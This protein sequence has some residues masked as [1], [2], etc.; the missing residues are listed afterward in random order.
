LIAI[1][2]SSW[3]SSELSARW[4]QSGGRYRCAELASQV[5]KLESAFARRAIPATALADVHG[6]RDRVN[7]MVR[8]SPLA[9]PSN[10][11]YAVFLVAVRSNAVLR[12]CCYRVHPPGRVT[13]CAG[14]G[15]AFWLSASQSK[16][17]PSGL[18]LAFAR[19]HFAGT[20]ENSFVSVHD[21]AK[22]SKAAIPGSCG[23]NSCAET[24][25]KA[26]AG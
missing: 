3:F 7:T 17:G 26:F 21:L 13:R 11:Q 2:Q 24:T 22:P 15:S 4:S 6:P 14:R 19:R 20:D 23:S 25:R 16:P 9:M 12:D 1:G 8:E 10:H 18:R 5:V